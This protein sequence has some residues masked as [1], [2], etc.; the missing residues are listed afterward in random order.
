MPLDQMVSTC[1]RS[2]FTHANGDMM[3]GPHHPDRSNDDDPPNLYVCRRRESHVL[4]PNTTS[5]SSVR[6]G[7]LLSA[8][9][10]AGFIQENPDHHM[11]QSIGGAC[12]CIACGTT[13]A[14]V[15]VDLSATC[16]RAEYG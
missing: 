3:R 7:V 1:A 15:A 6:E 12:G 2:D 5:V 8:D 4:S 10:S 14:T 16:C 9:G 11:T 13:K